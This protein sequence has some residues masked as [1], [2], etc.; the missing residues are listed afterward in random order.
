MNNAYLRCM[1]FVFL[2]Q[3]LQSEERFRPVCDGWSADPG[4]CC[5]VTLAGAR[6]F[7]ASRHDWHFYGWTC[8]FCDPNLHLT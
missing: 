8:R 6:G 3:S 5:T 7:L 4:V 2:M 1:S